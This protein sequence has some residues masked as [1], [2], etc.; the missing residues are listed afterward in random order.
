MKK[1]FA[2]ETND[3]SRLFWL[4][5]MKND[6]YIQKDIVNL[7]RYI[8]IIQPR[9]L[10]F[11]KENPHI[12]LDRFELLTDG[13]LHDED[14]VEIAMF[15]YARGGSFR[16]NLKC[17]IVGL[18]KKAVKDIKV[19]E[20]P[21]PNLEKATQ[22]ADADEYEGKNKSEEED[23]D[24]DQDGF[25]NKN[26]EQ[27]NKRHKSKKNRSLQMSE[28]LI[29]AP[30]S[31][32]GVLSFDETGGYVTIPDK[33]VVFTKR[34]D[35]NWENLEHEGVRMM[36]ELQ[37]STRHMDDNF[38]NTEIDL[39]EGVV[40]E[41]PEEEKQFRDF[42]RSLKQLS[43]IAM[44]VSDTTGLVGKNSSVLS[45]EHLIYDTKGDG[46][47]YLNDF[48]DVMDC[49]KYKTSL[50]KSRE[51]YTREARFKFVTVMA[52]CP[53]TYQDRE[54]MLLLMETTTTWMKR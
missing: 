42:K 33:Y 48:N 18:G 39:I 17:N 20:D 28:R 21:C 51:E 40:L 41:A 50:L 11:K 32:I 25:G 46:K 15:G 3:D 6:Y 29:Y 43:N 30:Q 22:L 52:F 23:D 12:V 9:K 5:G 36:R 16:Q 13:V 44:K 45:L 10:E 27:E 26:V 54:L 34:D 7:A 14:K 49:S 37:Q 47:T 4:R 53:V 8:S 24:I 31:N 1:R 35:E 2:S 38:E 19:L